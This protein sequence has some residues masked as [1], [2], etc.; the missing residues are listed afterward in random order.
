M[1]WE[2]S[3]ISSK[4]YGKKLGNKCI[5]N[6]AKRNKAIINLETKKSR[7]RKVMYL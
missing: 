7:T 5:E 6:Q 1:Y 2:D 3:N 4:D